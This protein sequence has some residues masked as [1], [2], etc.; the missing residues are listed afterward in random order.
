M[1]N[2]GF[3]LLSLCIGELFKVFEKWCDSIN[4]LWAGF[5]RVAFG[6]W[7]SLKDKISG[8][9]RDNHILKSTE[10]E[11]LQNLLCSS[12]HQTGFESH[13]FLG[14]CQ[15]LSFLLPPQHWEDLET[16]CILSTRQ[17]LF[18]FLDLCVST[19]TPGTS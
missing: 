14:M 7:L 4:K 1:P 15:I 3:G 9:G 11:Q 10:T 17:M 13:L 8:K 6:R 16:L 19:P 12:G 18:V 2:L 5:Q